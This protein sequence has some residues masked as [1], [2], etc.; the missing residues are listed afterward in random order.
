VASIQLD[1]FN[2]PVSD[3]GTALNA[4]VNKQHN[5]PDGQSFGVQVKVGSQREVFQSGGSAQ[6]VTNASAQLMELSSTGTTS[7]TS[8]L[9][10]GTRTDPQTEARLRIIAPHLFADEAT[11]RAAQEARAV[12]LKAAEAAESERT[13][14]NT[15]PHPE[16]EEA[17][18]AFA[19]LPTQDA[20]SLL[21][22]AQ[23]GQ[24]PTAAQL[25]R[26]A[27]SW[28]VSQDAVAAR[29]ELLNVGIQGQ[30]GALA[31]SMGVDPDEA[32]DY[33]RRTRPDTVMSVLQAHALRRDLM[34]WK[35][36]LNEFKTYKGSH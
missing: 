33:L 24:T 31:R 11:K 3:S 27:D 23:R 7:P 30:F 5:T 16:V 22:A 29:I 2:R 1:Q 32:A 13:S 12:E 18:A 17:H 36:L 15:H 25:G 34:A 28:G 8:V 4:E 21:V 20:V 26:L 14:I 19:A 6:R 9:L 10:D 35:P